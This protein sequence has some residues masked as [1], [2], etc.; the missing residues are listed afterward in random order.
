MVDIEVLWAQFDSLKKENEKP[1]TDPYEDY[2]CK[3]CGGQKI[4]DHSELPVCSECGIMDFHYISDEPEWSS[5]IDND[6]TVKDGARCGEAVDNGFFSIGWNMGTKISTFGY[7]TYADKKMARIAF[8]SSMNH[9]DRSLFHAYAEI[10]KVC[11]KL[12]CLKNVSD[13]A[14]LLYKEF[15]EKKLTRGDV[16][17]GVKANC[18][19]IACKQYNVPRTTKEIADALNIDSKDVGRTSQIFNE[20][21][22]THE[23][24]KV[25]MPKDIIPRILSAMNIEDRK[26]KCSC[27]KLCETVERHKTLMGKTPSGVAAASIFILLNDRKNDICKASGISVPTLNKMER[28]IREI[29]NI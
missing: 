10:D 9:K 13:S 8:H 4:F 2:F 24:S 1:K 7:S 15:T 5:G 19:F 23:S 22:K 27:V 29:T 16:R 26:F 21:I 18:I 20:T 25:T 14:K 17:A 11:G 28:A 12:N 6:G 3:H